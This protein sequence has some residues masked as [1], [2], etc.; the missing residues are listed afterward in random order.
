M[1]DY[2]EW[3][4]NFFEKEKKKARAKISNAAELAEKLKANEVQRD[5]LFAM[6]RTCWMFMTQPSFITNI[7]PPGTY[8]NDYGC[9]YCQE[10]KQ[11]CCKW[12]TWW[13]FCQY[14]VEGEDESKVLV[15]MKNTLI[16]FFILLSRSMS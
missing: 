12:P 10:K 2:L 14:W 13:E 11:Y 16:F 7:K 6:L 4:E 1:V 3:V 5:K 9:P 15:P 8:F